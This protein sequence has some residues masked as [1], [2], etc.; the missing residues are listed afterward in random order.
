MVGRRGIEMQE[1]LT[2]NW[3]ALY[4]S[5]VGTIALIVNFSK[6]VH[7]I[8]KDKVKLKL[9][10]APH[11]ERQ[12]NLQRLKSTENNQ[13]WDKPNLVESYQITIRNVGNVDAHIED[14]GVI[15]HDGK[16]HQVLISYPGNSCTLG[17]LAEVGSAT[18]PAKS[19]KKMNVYQKRGEGVFIANKVFVTDS[20][21]KK[22]IAS[23]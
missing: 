2:E 8:R 14:A 17:R 4:G 6:F 11:P 9:M 3:L 10:V 18:I 19:S 22:W 16:I 7:A 13:P 15:C 12:K 21:G 1:W 23:A 20:T 5:I